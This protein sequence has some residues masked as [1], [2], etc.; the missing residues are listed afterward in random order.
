[1]CYSENS[2][3]YPRKTHIAIPFLNCEFYLWIRE[4]L[5]IKTMRKHAEWRDEFVIFKVSCC[6]DEKFADS[7][8]RLKS[9]LIRANAIVKEAN[10]ISSSL[11]NGRP[12]INYDVTL[13]IPAANLRPSRIKVIIGLK[14]SLTNSQTYPFNTSHRRSQPEQP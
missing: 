14:Y 7:L 2:V 4:A 11:N 1:M 9:D 5:C 3:L 10:L 8:A 13:Q 12:K 6:R